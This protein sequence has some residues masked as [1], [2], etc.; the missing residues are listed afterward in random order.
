MEQMGS[1]FSD[2]EIERMIR[3]VDKDGNGMISIEE[4][5]VLLEEP[6]Y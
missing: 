6:E 1:H 2:K 4:F 5:S 3:S